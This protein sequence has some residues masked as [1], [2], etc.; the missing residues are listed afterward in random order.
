MHSVPFAVH[1]RPGEV[2]ED[3]FLLAWNSTDHESNPDLGALTTPHD[4]PVGLKRAGMDDLQ[5]PQAIAVA[6][7]ILASSVAVVV[8]LMKLNRNP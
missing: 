8:T 4:V 6:T 5:F 1:F 7:T 2:P 3:V